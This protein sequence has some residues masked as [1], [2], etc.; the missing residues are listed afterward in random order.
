MST[1]DAWALGRGLYLRF[2]SIV[3]AIS[4]IQDRCT[5]S[6]RHVFIALSLKPTSAAN[7]VH[8]ATAVATSTAHKNQDRL[9]CACR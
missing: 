5:V 9:E 4:G 2:S 1:S 3:G 6:N 7:T 8:T